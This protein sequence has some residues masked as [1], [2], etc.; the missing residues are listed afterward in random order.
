M[1][2]LRQTGG[3][4]MIKIMFDMHL[5][6][7]H[8]RV[9]TIIDVLEGACE[10]VMIEQCTPALEEKKKVTHYMNGMRNKGISGEALLIELL[11]NG[12]KTKVELALGFAQRGFAKSS[13]SPMVSKAV[14]SGKV[15]M[16]DGIIAI[17]EPK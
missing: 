2:S 17:K 1:P 13:V 10:V 15:I 11:K 12:G 4:G 6:V 9:S 14:Q 8:E 3:S 16:K 5:R 7:P